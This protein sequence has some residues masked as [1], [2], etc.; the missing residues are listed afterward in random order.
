MYDPK[1]DKFEIL[2]N[3]DYLETKSEMEKINNFLLSIDTINYPYL[4]DTCKELEELSDR[5]F[6][7]LANYDK[8]RLEKIN[9]KKR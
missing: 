5:I 1:K 6:A 7:S 8:K 4:A 9:S 2:N 3:V